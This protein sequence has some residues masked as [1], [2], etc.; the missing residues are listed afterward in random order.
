MPPPKQKRQ[1]PGDRVAL[2]R[3]IEDISSKV[4]VAGGDP[5]PSCQTGKHGLEFHAPG[6]TSHPAMTFDTSRENSLGKA[7]FWPSRGSG[8]KALNGAG[9]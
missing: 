1:G 9:L 7:V 2:P 4:L 8:R 3:R 5:G 6:R